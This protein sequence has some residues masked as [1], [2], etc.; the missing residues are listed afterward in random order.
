MKCPGGSSACWGCSDDPK[1]GRD[2]TPILG[3]TLVTRAED[4]G[5]VLP[6]PVPSLQMPTPGSPGAVGNVWGGRCGRLAEPRS[7]VRVD[8]SCSLG[9]ATET[10]GVG[11]AG[12]R[13]E[14]QA[15]A[16]CLISSHLLV[17]SVQRK[18]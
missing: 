1:L 2:G 17:C 14:V 16:L 11:R 6:F 3:R 12:K 7:P 5:L 10:L 18:I 9:R 13:R 15:A 4:G 8:Q